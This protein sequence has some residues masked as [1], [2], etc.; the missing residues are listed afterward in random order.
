MKEIP[1]LYKQRGSFGNNTTIPEAERSFI[2]RLGECSDSAK[3]RGEQSLHS[4]FEENGVAPKGTFIDFEG[5]RVPLILVKPWEQPFGRQKQ[6][7]L[8]KT[9]RN[10]ELHIQRQN[11][12]KI[13]Q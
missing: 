6:Y 7:K 10:M 1:D 2:A 3:L 4:F 13:D 8:S 9:A 12:D 11:I 5:R